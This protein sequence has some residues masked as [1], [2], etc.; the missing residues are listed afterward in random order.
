MHLERDQRVCLAVA[1]L[2]ADRRNG[3]RVTVDAIPEQDERN[4]QAVEMMA[5]DGVGPI[6]LEHTTIEPFPGSIEAS[7]FLRKVF[8]RHSIEVPGIDPESWYTL[9]IRPLTLAGA[10]KDTDLVRA[11]I[12]EW[13]ERT[14]P[15]LTLS[16]FRRTE[17]FAESAEGE[18]PLP[19]FLAR[20]EGVEGSPFNGKVSVGFVPPD[21]REHLRE[22]RVFRAL[23][24]KLPKLLTARPED[25][26]AVLVLETFDLPLTNPWVVG[27]ALRAASARCDHALPEYVVLI[28]T[29]DE[30]LSCVIYDHGTWPDETLTRLTFD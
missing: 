12:T 20:T 18:L 3:G 2:I 24:A 10:A 21:D 1:G 7:A 22:D 8:P 11:Q 6:A 23:E 13:M 9:G 15:T 5:R 16:T 29:I 25:G 27:E 26:T 4:A 17:R 30:P 28:I 14:A 19:V